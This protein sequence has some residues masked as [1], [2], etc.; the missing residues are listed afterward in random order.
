MAVAALHRKESRGAQFRRDFPQRDDEN[1]LKHILVRYSPE[2]PSLDYCPVPI[3]RWQP[4]R[5]VY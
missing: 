2:G 5:R 3:T 4:E 1:W